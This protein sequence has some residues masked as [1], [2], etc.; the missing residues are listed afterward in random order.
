MHDLLPQLNQWLETDKTIMIATVTATW[1]S[2]PRPIGSKMIFTPDGTMHGSV[3]GGCV[4]TAVIST[5]LDQPS[6]SQQLTFGVSDETAQSV[7]LACGGQISVF[8]TPLD[9]ALYQF[10]QPHWHQHTPTATITIIATPT[11][12]LGR[13][14]ALTPAGDQYNDL[15][16]HTATARQLAHDALTNHTSHTHQL[17]DGTQLFIDIHLP[18]PTLIIIGAVHIAIH[19]VT[20][21]RAIGYQT[22]IIDPRRTFASGDRF[23]HADHCHSLWPR[24]AFAT[25]PLTNQTA[26][27]LLSH[28][29]KIDDPALRLALDSPAFYIGALGSRRTQAAR[30]Q[31]LQADGYAETQLARLHGPIGLNIHA[32]TPAEI[33]LAIMA[34]IVAVQRAPTDE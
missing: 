9:H 22:I 16:P 15:G 10:L 29:P 11:N 6:R 24:K 18:P 27:A 30:R 17:D 32:R 5:G 4:E 31:R 7:G 13:Q 3:S 12:H 21:A 2:A 14:M 1:G 28:D 20:F 23:A 33:A 34:E 25:I 8:L 26:V 19:L